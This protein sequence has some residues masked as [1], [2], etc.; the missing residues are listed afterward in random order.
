MARPK[1]RGGKKKVKKLVPEGIVHI[2][3]TFNNTIITFTDLQ[4]N[5]VAWSTAG[6]QGFKGS[7]K[8]TPFAAQMAA[9]EA[10][11]KAQDCG[12]KSAFAYLKGP[13]GGRESALRAINASGMKITGIKDVTPIPHNGCRPPKRRRV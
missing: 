9:Q 4:G 5:T 2:Q 3:A 10:C 1:Q 12:M 7:R 6:S 11:K 13:G 8:S